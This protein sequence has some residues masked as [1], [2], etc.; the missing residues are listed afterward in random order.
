MQTLLPRKKVKRM[1]SIFNR[2][3]VLRINLLQE[4]K[5]LRLSQECVVK[6]NEL[7]LF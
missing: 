1:D 5:T 3:T 2:I 4:P 6:L 7:T